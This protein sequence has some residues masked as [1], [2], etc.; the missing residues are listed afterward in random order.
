MQDQL[1]QIYKDV[2]SRSLSRQEALEKIKTLIKGR[3]RVLL[4]TPRWQEIEEDRTK[5]PPAFRDDG[6][7]LI[8]GGL[9]ALGTLLMQEIVLRSPGARVILTGRSESASRPLPER[10]S[11]RQL[12]LADR[13]H[14]GS[15][16]G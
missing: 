15:A 11:Y 9:G 5:P 4:A 2:F 16:T 1:R 7:Y 10:V 14:V 3:S 8:T 12:D 13:H 6:V